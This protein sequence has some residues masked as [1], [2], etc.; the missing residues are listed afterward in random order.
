MVI[1][2][3]RRSQGI[4]TASNQL[5]SGAPFVLTCELAA[6]EK[7]RKNKVTTNL[8]LITLQ[9]TLFNEI[10]IRIQFEKKSAH[11]GIQFETYFNYLGF[12]KDGY[13]GNSQ[14]GSSDDFR[15]YGIV[16]AQGTGTC[17]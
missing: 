11:F 4:S 12:F 8:N 1:H 3:F 6:T 5:T 16:P 2:Q 15:F 17:S 7:K 9:I 13:E 14:S 10:N